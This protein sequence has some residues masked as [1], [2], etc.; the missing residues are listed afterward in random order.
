[1]YQLKIKQVCFIIIAFLPVTKF[2]M[3]NSVIAGYAD[4]DMWIS[5]L[6]NLILD[7]LAVL[8]ILFVYKKTGKRF[9]DLI[10]ENFGVIGEKI[11]LS[12]FLIYFIFKSIIPIFEQKDYI[13][14]TLYITMPKIMYFLPFF[15]A[16]FY[17]CQ[18][19]LQSIGRIAELTFSLAIIG[20]IL[21]IVLSIKNADYGAILPVN[22]NNTS[23]IINGSLHAQNW[24]GDGAYLLFLIGEFKWEKK[25][26]LKIILS[27]LLSFFMV[28][29]FSF[30]FYTIFKS[31]AFRQRFAMTEVTK[32]STVI[33]NTGRFDYVGISLITFVNVFSLS[34]P[35]FFASRLITEIFGLRKRWICS[36]IINA[37][38]LT[39]L[40]V[41]INDFFYL[42][43]FILNYVSFFFIGV[44]TVIPLL[45][46]LLTVKGGYREVY[47]N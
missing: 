45:L 37:S 23:G 9:S 6:L 28:L 5:V 31:I 21:L 27:Y 14:L 20:Y 24:F 39:V 33:N 30:L 10:R 35:M 17:I 4:N 41:F 11:M 18:Q 36:L 3:M 22:N 8:S 1:M 15:F 44:G 13:I 42:E 38:L 46:P 34:L 43:T 2:F 25:C 29:L 12:L 16:S 26:D 32:Y 40:L 19:K 47:K 7:F